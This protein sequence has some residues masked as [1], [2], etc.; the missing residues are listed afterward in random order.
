MA[1]GARAAL[2]RQKCLTYWSS[3]NT[4]SCEPR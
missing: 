1:K 2:V 4:F 3:V